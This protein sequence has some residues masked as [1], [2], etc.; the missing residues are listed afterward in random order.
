MK[1]SAYFCLIKYF[2]NTCFPTSALLCFFKANLI[3]HSIAYR[4][5]QLWVE[6]STLL[7][8]STVI[9]HV[10]DPVTLK[11]IFRSERIVSAHITLFW[12]RTQLQGQLPGFHCKW[13]GTTA[14]SLHWAWSYT[15]YTQ[16]DTVLLN[17]S[18]CFKC[19]I[20]TMKVN[21]V[22][23]QNWCSS[24]KLHEWLIKLRLHFK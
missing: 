21:G 4:I 13:S 12:S 5:A 3:T 22:H 17:V 10:L 24:L 1:F 15:D 8:S 20:L 7:L 11:P 19:F 2:L 18:T 6:S 23:E 9:N 14:H 16:P